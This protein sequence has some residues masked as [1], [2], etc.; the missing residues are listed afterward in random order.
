MIWSLLVIKSFAT[1]DGLSKEYEVNFKELNF[2]V[3][4]VRNNQ[5]VLGARMMGGGFEGCTINLVKEAAVDKLIDNITPVY[6]EKMGL[7]LK[8]Y[9][10]SLNIGTSVIE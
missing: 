5:N 2:L 10:V 8:T 3:D 9:I 6:K 4:E 7:D 1:H